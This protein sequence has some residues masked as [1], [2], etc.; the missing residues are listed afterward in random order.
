M[1]HVKIMLS[2]L[3]QKRKISL[4]SNLMSIEMCQGESSD[5]ALFQLNEQKESVEACQQQCTKGPEKGLPT[6]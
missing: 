1:I 6:S 3:I 5:S 2:F 4:K